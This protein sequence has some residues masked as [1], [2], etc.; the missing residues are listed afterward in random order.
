MGSEACVLIWILFDLVQQEF[1]SSGV[2][3]TVVD[4]KS[5]L[6]VKL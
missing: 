4:Q 2:V 5:K 3:L 1:V 6:D